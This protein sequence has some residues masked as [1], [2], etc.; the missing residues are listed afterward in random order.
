MD[1]MSNFHIKNVP[2]RLRLIHN[3]DISLKNNYIN[4]YIRMLRGV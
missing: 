4:P 3:Q 2:C 1:K